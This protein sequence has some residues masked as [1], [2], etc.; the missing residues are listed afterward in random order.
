MA[1]FY[2]KTLPPTAARHGNN[3]LNSGYLIESADS[4]R[5][6]TRLPDTRKH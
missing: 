6:L 2:P 4:G 1:Q 5:Q 3:L